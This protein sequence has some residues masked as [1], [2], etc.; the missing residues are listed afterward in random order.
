MRLGFHHINKHDFLQAYPKA[1]DKVFTIQNAQSAFR[2]TGIVPYDPKEVLKRFNHSIST[3]TPPLAE[4]VPQHLPLHLPRL[5]EFD[6]YIRKL[7]L[8]KRCL[9]GVPRVLLVL[10]NVL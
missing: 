5:I 9:L 7:L 2:A 3:P 4:G 8:L 10:L 6:S 1:R